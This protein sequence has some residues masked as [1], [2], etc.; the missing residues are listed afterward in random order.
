LVLVV[1]EVLEQELHRP[2]AGVLH[3][4]ALSLLVVVLVDG[5]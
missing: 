5:G 2:M 1:L 4:T 3:L